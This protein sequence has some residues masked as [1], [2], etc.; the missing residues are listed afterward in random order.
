MAGY[1]P[2][3]VTQADV[4]RAAGG[5]DRPPCECVYHPDTDTQDS[6]DCLLHG[7][8]AP[9]APAPMCLEPLLGTS[10][11]P[12]QVR[13]FLDCSARWWFKYGLRLREPKNGNLAL[14]IAVH[15]ALEANFREKLDTKEDLPIAGVTAVFRQAWAVIS[16][17]TEFRDDEDPR[18]IAQV[19]EILVAKYMEEAAPSIEPAAVELDVNGE[20][21]GVK[22][23]GK[24]DLIDTD[25][26]VVD[27][28]TSARRP[29]GIAPDY[30]FQ[31]ATYRQL[32]PGANGEARLNTL[33]KTKTVQLIQQSYT[34]SEA[35]LKSTQV[36]YPLVQEGIR[37]GLYFPNRQSTLCSR[38]NCAFWRQCERDF[39]GI[40]EE[41]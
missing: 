36:L 40:V 28:K 23:L 6:E 13:S 16:T 39:G 24:V 10:L 18:E 34:V 3:G 9:H 1:Y 30:A 14:G 31:L 15:Q 12:T 20:I 27:V 32:A 4:D 25:G 2:D 17:E 35:D 8:R 7:V 22:V 29:S 37:N 5:Y 38:R 11:S 21:G 19:G 26:R 41:S 33:V